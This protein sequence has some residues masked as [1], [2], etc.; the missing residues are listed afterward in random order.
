MASRDS[1]GTSSVEVEDET[2]TVN[3]VHPKG[4]IDGDQLDGQS[5]HQ[6]SISDIAEFERV[7][8]SDVS[9]VPSNGIYHTL[10]TLVSDWN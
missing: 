4:I 8:Q 10:L 2:G 7:L 9:D 3:A 5:P 1:V 6:P